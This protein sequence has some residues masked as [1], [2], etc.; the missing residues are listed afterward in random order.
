MEL[1]VRKTDEISETLR[2]KYLYKNQSFTF[3]VFGSLILWPFFAIVT[4]PA[5]E[6]HPGALVSRIVE[7]GLTSLKNRILSRNEVL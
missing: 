4:A 5:I 6:L 2:S 7:E 3:R 1:L